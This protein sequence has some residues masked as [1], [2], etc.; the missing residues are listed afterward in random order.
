MKKKIVVVQI[1]PRV[2]Q[3]LGEG[4]MKEASKSI[5]DLRENLTNK[6]FHYSSPSN[7]NVRS[8]PAIKGPFI[9]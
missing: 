9:W 2:L 3:V 7:Q 6:S 4:T 5:Q 1:V 8:I